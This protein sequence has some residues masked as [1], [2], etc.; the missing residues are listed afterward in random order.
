[1]ASLCRKTYL[2]LARRT[3]EEE[4]LVKASK[5]NIVLTGATGLLAQ[6]CLTFLT[7]DVS[8]VASAEI[9]LISKVVLPSPR[10]PNRLALFPSG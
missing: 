2:R 5:L 4:P 6:S 7:Y 9:G 3:A 1:M 10:A 8:V